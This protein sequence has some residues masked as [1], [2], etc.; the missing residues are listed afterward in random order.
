MIHM[1]SMSLGG[2]PVNIDE[3]GQAVN[4]LILDTGTTYFAVPSF[5]IRNVL[6]LTKSRLCRDL[7]DGPSLEIVL[8]DRDDRKVTLRLEP[9]EYMVTSVAPENVDAANH[10]LNSVCDPAFMAIDVPA[11]HGPAFLLGEVFMRSTHF[12]IRFMIHFENVLQNIES[13]SKKMY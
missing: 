8:R 3:N 7:D 6:S 1:E 12:N 11:D 9:A 4:R 13:I 5:A 2:V 10:G